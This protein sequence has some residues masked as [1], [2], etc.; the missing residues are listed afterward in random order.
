MHALGRYGIDRAL[1]LA[2]SGDP[3]SS[4]SLNRRLRELSGIDELRKQIDG[5]QLRT[6]ALKAETALTELESISWRFQL[7]ELRD[8]IDRMRFEA[9]LLELMKLFDRC[10]TGEIELEDER[11]AELERLLVGRTL[12]ERLCLD[13]LPTAEDIRAAAIQRARSWRTWAGGGLASFQGQQVA[14]KVDDV[15]MQ[16][17]FSEEEAE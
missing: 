10:A 1:E 12:P 14:R 2:D 13:G 17:A 8:R 15:Y 3:F 5:L 11:L 6:D 9:P 16:I 4:I 7:T